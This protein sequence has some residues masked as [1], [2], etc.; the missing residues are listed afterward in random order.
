MFRDVQ[1]PLFLTKKQS[2]TENVNEFLQEQ[3]QNLLNCQQY[4]ISEF[5]NIIV[6]HK[7]K[8]SLF[9]LNI[10]SLHY[11]FQDLNDLLKSLKHNF[12][13]IGITESQLKVNS[14]PLVNIHRP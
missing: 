14:Q 6:N 8:F 3:S 10:S 4:N 12:S 13:I 9:R 5:N 1:I 11:H 7:E 2:F